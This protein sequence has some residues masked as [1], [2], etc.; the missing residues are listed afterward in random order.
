M[1]FTCS[2]K[3]DICFGCLA[4][5]QHHVTDEESVKSKSYYLLIALHH[6][7]DS[8]LEITQRLF[9]PRFHLTFGL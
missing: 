3:R 5:P 1:N 9:F 7:H 4:L 2:F 8:K 6:G